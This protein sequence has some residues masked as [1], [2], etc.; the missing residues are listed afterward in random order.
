VLTLGIGALGVA[1]SPAAAAQPA[2][3]HA[4]LAYA[5]HAAAVPGIAPSGAD[6][7]AVFLDSAGRVIPALSA[8]RASSPAD[9]AGP[10]SIDSGCTPVSGRDNPHRSSTGIAVSGHGWWD[11]GTCTNNTA[12]VINCLYEYYT[13][14]SWRQKACSPTQTLAPGGGSGNRTTA[15]RDCG[16]TQ[17]T[18]WRNYVDVDVI[19]E[20]DTPEQ[21]YNQADVLCRVY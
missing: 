12:N 3:P 11:K 19:G 7:T 21:P 5:S 18:S 8:S 6:R 13:D 15:R 4:R 17:D 20:S 2:G 14:N 16:D 1:I 9:A 10:M